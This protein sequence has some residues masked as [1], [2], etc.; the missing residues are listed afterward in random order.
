MDNWDQLEVGL[1]L[2]CMILCVSMGFDASVSK[3]ISSSIQEGEEDTL[4][5]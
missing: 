4:F 5:K 1:H 2:N 3:A